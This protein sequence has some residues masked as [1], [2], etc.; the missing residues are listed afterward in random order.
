MEAGYVA[1]EGE[2]DKYDN[3]K[4]VVNENYYVVPHSS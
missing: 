1:K 4:D 3:Y 2:K